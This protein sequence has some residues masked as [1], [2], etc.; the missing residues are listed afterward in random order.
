MEAVTAE[1]A[2]CDGFPPPPGLPRG[3]CIL[4]WVN[5]DDGTVRVERADPRILISAEL[6]DSIARDQPPQARLDPVASTTCSGAVLRITGVNRTVIYRIGQ[7]LPAVH[8]YL[9]EWPD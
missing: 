8:G 9:A 2:V 5:F 6:L 1:L 7:Y 3:D 4:T